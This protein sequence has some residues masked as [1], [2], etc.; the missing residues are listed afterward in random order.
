MKKLSKIKLQ[1]AVK[2]EEKEMKGIFGGSGSGLPGGCFNCDCGGSG[3]NPP[4][5]SSW[6]KIYINT[7]SMYDDI[8]RRCVGGSGG[9]SQTA[10]SNC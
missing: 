1:N 5:V 7:T 9:C 3:A 2:L 6:T 4:Y 10:L 8:S